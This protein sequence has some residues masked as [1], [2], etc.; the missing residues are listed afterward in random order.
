ST[1]LL[2]SLKSLFVYLEEARWKLIPTCRH[3]S[4][5][6]RSNS[7]TGADGKRSLRLTDFICSDINSFSEPVF[8]LA[9]PKT[10]SP[11][12]V[13]VTNQ[14]LKD[15]NNPNSFNDVQINVFTWKPNGTADPNIPFDWRC[16]V[17]SNPIIL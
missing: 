7:R 12:Y 14:L 2:V 3:N 9:T 1:L 8:L 11:C 16:R 5:K 4:Q 17:V 15:P 6:S 13:T 10:E